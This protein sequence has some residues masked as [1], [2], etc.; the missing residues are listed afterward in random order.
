MLNLKPKTMKKLKE[1]FL[2]E[3]SES[4]MVYINGGKKWKTHWSG[5]G[6]PLVYFGEAVYNGVVLIHN[7]I[8]D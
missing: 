7:A 4:E 6:N 2:T 1:R 5:T 3:M 8:F